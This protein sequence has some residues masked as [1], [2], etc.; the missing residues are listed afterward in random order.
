MLEWQAY[1]LRVLRI[2]ADTAAST[3][4]LD[5]MGWDGLPA[6]RMATSVTDDVESIRRLNAL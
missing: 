6:K 2:A 4:T 5:S 1:R 3:E